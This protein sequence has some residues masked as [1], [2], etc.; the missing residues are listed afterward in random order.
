MPAKKFKWYK[1]ADGLSDIAFGPNNL[2]EV[3]AGNQ[4]ICIS[5]TSKGLQACIG[6]CPHAGGILSEG[7]IDKEENL[8]CPLHHYKFNLINGRNISGEGYYLKTYPL[9][10]R[11]D[12]IFIGIEEK[13]I[14]GW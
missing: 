6:K 4:I 10:T 3:S 14:F 9:E 5:K 8:V 13:G 12:G 2:T 7:F 1:I 11:D